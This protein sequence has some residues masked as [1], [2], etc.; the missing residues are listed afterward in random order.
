MQATYATKSSVFSRL[1]VEDYPKR[2]NHYGMELVLNQIKEKYY[3][4][5]MR[6]TVKDVFRKCQVCRV[7]RALPK[8]MGNLPEYR[9]EAGLPVF[10][11]TGMDYFGPI[12]VTVNR[13][14]EKRYGVIFTCLNSRA[15]HIEVAGSLTTDAAIM[16]VRR[17]ISRRPKP[18]MIISDNGTNLR[19]AAVELKQS[20]ADLD[21]ENIANCLS[22][23]SIDWKFIPPASPHYGGAWERVVRSVK[24]ALNAVLKE[25]FP[26]EETL[27]TL[28][29]E[30][31]HLVNNRPLT[32]VSTDPEDSRSITPND[33]LLGIHQSTNGAP[34]VFYDS[35]EILRKQWRYAQLLFDR[36]WS[37]WV[38]EY[39]STLQSRTKW[40]AAVDNVKV[41]DLVKITEP[42]VSRGEWPLGRVVKV[43]TGEDE[44]VRYAD[45]RT[46]NSTL[47]RPVT[48][49]AIIEGLD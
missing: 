28:L 39:L 19:G 4:S 33:L 36:F 18:R 3:F 7:N 20:L 26:K 37:R 9:L 38:R 45:V 13:H 44:L 22:A 31:E 32:Y 34:R 25:K 41:G 5:K 47:R 35:Y 14:H 16:A 17:F 43:Y 15:V 40:K 49:L 12:T 10:A 21:S 24:I 11:F 2:A 27:Y 30:V 42:K 29:V 6:A 46:Q 1:L 48:K 8:E 23:H